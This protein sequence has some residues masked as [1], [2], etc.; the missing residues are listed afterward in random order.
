M[1]L[2][3]SN[4]KMVIR[5][6]DTHNILRPETVFV[7]Q[8]LTL[9][10]VSHENTCRHGEH[11]NDRTATHGLGGI[12][13]LPVVCDAGSDVPGV[14]LGDRNALRGAT[15]Y[16]RHWHLYLCHSLLPFW[17]VCSTRQGM[18]TA[19]SGRVVGRFDLKIKSRGLTQ[20]G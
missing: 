17:Q 12:D 18:G 11:H 20:E 10:P 13:L 14:G 4:P 2:E 3:G 5:A 15:S 19:W 1:P 7:S 8:W 16:G 9:P 6:A